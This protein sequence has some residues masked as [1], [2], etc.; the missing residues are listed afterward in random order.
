VFPNA[1]NQLF[2]DQFVNAH[3]LVD[4]LAG[5]VRV[6]TAAVQVGQ[7]G[8]FVWLIAANGKVT[9]QAV[10]LGPTDGQFEQVLTGLKPGDRVV[11]DGSDRL[12]DGMQVSVTPAP[13]APGSAVQAAPTAGQRRRGTGQRKPAAPPAP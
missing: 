2:A 11:S 6:P 5:V 3:L 10:T 7:P 13:P 9:S 1:Q 8:A 4:T 12:K